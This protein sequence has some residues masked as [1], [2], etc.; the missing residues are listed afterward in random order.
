MNKFKSILLVLITIL[1]F[2]LKP[3]LAKAD[4]CAGGEV[5]YQ[6]V[7]DSTYRFF[8][9]FYRDC[10]GID[11]YA[12]QPLCGFNSCTGT[13]V[14]TTMSQWGGLIP[15]GVPN[16]SDV[17]TGC[18]L[19]PTKCQSTASTIPGYQEFWYSGIVTLP[20]RCNFWT[21]SVS[22]SARNVSANINGG[23]LYLETTFDNTDPA[24]D[25]NSSPYFSIKPVPYCCINQAYS[26][27]NGAVDPN[28]DSLVTEIMAPQTGGG[29]PS[30][31]TQLAWK[32]GSPPYSIPTNPI[33]TN[34]TFTTNA[35]TGQLSF[36]P[37]AIG[38][39]T[40]T[41][42]V[43]E[44]RNG[45]L[46]G[47][48]MRDVQVQIMQCTSQTID[49]KPKPPSNGGSVDSFVRGCVD[50]PLNFC[51]DITCLDTT[52][53]LKVEDNH[54]A[55][56]PL[57]TIT[58]TNQGTDSVRGCL[59]WTPTIR[60]TGRR[61]IIV[62]VKDSTCRPPGIMV[63]SSY[64]IPIYIWAPTVGFR[65]TIICPGGPAYLTVKGG[66]DFV[67]SVLPGGDPVTTLS[68][69][70]CTAPTVR[71]KDTTL[72]VVTS[73]IN[74]YCGD[75]TKDTIKVTVIPGPEFTPI[76]DPILTCPNNTVQLDLQPNPPAGTTY[77]YKWTPSTYLSNDTIPNPVAIPN[78]DIEY[79]V[80][81]TNPKSICKGFDTVKIDVLDGFRIVTPDTA[82]CNG[83]S[84]NVNVVGDPRYDYSW[85]SSPPTDA[86]IDN[87]LIINPVITPGKTG[88]FK[89]TLKASN[90]S[91]TTDSF[92]SFTIDN[93]PIPSVTVDEDAIMCFGDTMQMHGVII[94]GDYPYTL[95]WTP[96]ESFD[97]PAAA[98]AI[99]KAS[100]VGENKLQLKAYSSAGCS[101]S[102]DVT[103]TVFKA[104]FLA[105]TP[106][107]TALCPG[108]SVQLHLSTTG[109]KSFTWHP[110]TEI[111]SITGLDPFVWPTVTQR[112]AAY[113][114]DTNNCLD[115]ASILVTIKPKAVIEIPDTVN[116]YP[117][118]SY[119]INPSGNCLYFKW[120][121]TVSLNNPDIS[122]PLASPA[123]NTRYIVT[124]STEFGCMATDAIDILVMP[125]SYFELPNAFVAGGGLPFKP[126]KLGSS[127]LKSFMIYNRWGTK[128]FETKDINLGW[129]GTYNNELQPAGV[130]IYT[131]EATSANGHKISKQGNV[132]LI[133]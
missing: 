101:D 22:V 3:N 15:P 1:S 24:N 18:S 71:P 58:Y 84:V 43:K 107:D 25:S 125:D 87:P 121:P 85:T 131:I 80:E 47:S 132:T 93:Q 133:R 129:D 89:Y 66:R 79:R 33:Q 88:S 26:F 95:I 59:S 112:Y 55:S 118:D 9:K 78:N 68:C 42:R 64:V 117:G 69:T 72:Y 28:S 90:T 102:D 23:N 39:P 115:T 75:N 57:A 11:A 111:S 100:I 61:D 119:H 45:K 124:A 127:T 105:L 98:N 29:C 31:P 96:G 108:D 52:G 104:D 113:G 19:Y 51:Y 92:A 86:G 21:F 34:N 10:T 70:N 128:V 7:S 49:V 4:H 40:L 120:F 97:N 53:I 36:I 48:I 44:Y 13:T 16:G 60:D 30:T 122:D 32:G 82:I 54:A 5:L 65:D 91:C 81:I 8:F 94:P 20:E 12:T 109:I 123:V 130:Y 27:N 67:W 2:T 106:N 114:I 126:I 56:L 46:L 103:I 62:T 17:A 37:G 116:L 83:Q 74:P 35:N 63:Y 6:W 110:T 41:V 99:Y 73:T 76:A 77:R 14:T 38:N 50:A